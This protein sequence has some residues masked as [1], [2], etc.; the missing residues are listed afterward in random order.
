MNNK[1]KS[2]FIPDST[3]TIVTSAFS[4]NEKYIT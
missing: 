3:T 4:Q 1:L 2:I